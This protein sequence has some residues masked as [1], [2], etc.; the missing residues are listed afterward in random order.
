MTNSQINGADPQQA[1]KILERLLKYTANIMLIEQEPDVDV[2]ALARACASRIEDLVRILPPLSRLKQVY[3]HCPDEAN[4]ILSL[5]SELDSSV[6]R[7]VG[8]LER[9]RDALAGELGIFRGSQK[10][11]NAYTRSR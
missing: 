2:V 7:C 6:N 11:I 8:L 10:V 4:R 9:R 5:L 3:G 1:L